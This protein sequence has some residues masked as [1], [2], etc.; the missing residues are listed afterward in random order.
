MNIYVPGIRRKFPISYWS[1][2]MNDRFDFRKYCSFLFGF[3]CFLPEQWPVIEKTSDLDR[4]H[5]A[6]SFLS[7]MHLTGL[8]YFIWRGNS[9][10]YKVLYW[11][12]RYCICCDTFHDNQKHCLVYKLYNCRIKPVVLL[13]RVNTDLCVDKI[14]IFFKTYTNAN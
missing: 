7:F 14:L 11:F 3:D 6:T 13:N 1:K 10:S 12:Y 9:D 2:I 5:C 8:W 4:S